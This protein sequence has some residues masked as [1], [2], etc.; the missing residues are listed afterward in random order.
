MDSSLGYPLVDIQI[1]LNDGK[2]HP[3]DSSDMAFQIAGSMAF[4]TAIK[5]ADPCLLEPIMNVSISAPG[6]VYGKYHRRPER[7]KRAGDGC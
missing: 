1:H 2:Y 3:V 5:Q 4:A 6:T 7:T